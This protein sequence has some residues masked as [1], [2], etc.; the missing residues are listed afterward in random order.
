MRTLLFFVFFYPFFLLASPADVV[1]ITYQEKMGVYDFQVTVSHEDTGWEH[2]ANIWYILDENGGMIA[3]RK[4]WHPH[5]NEQPFTRSLRGVT[6][7]KHVKII[8]ICAGDNIGTRKG[9]CLQAEVNK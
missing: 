5:V 4:L 7:P 2:Y 8:T 6:L 3:S 9:R 1:K